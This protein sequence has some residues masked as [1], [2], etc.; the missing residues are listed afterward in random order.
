MKK[1]VT[2]IKNGLY[3]SSCKYTKCDSDINIEICLDK[4]VSNWL[5]MGGAITEATAYNYSK[6]N[7]SDKKNYIK[8]VF[9]DK[10]IDYN[11]VRLGIASNDFSLEPYQYTYKNDLS[12]FSLEKDKAY[13]VPLLD[14]VYKIKRPTLIASPWSPPSFM[15]SNKS[16]F[17][18][19]HLK[20]KYYDLYA[21]YLIKYIDEYKKM[22]Y[23]ID[24]LTIQNEPHAKQRWESCIFSLK[25]QKDFIY[26]YLLK[27]LSDTKVLIWDHN[28]EKL[29]KVMD[30]VYCE[31]KLVS[32]IGF[33]WYTGLYFN[34]IHDVRCKY[35]N[36]LVINT[37][38]CCGFSKYDEVSWVSDAELYLE[39]IIGCMNNGVNAYLEWNLLLDYNGGP[40]HK[41]NYVKSSIIL[42]ED[43]ST[44]IK[45]QFIIMFVI[46]LS[47]LKK[48]L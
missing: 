2:D 16:L 36:S 44:Y 10:G 32:G 20:H 34:N 22:G 26:N 7:K 9:S 19:G 15:K 46:F 39:D 30:K 42:N 41:E 38:M 31:N 33:H 45:T 5:G 48:I 24:Y 43:A 8:D 18:G 1:I 14:E 17:K 35:P 12:D 3:L 47:I 37:E 21:D 23:K 11:F 6:L 27:K 25:D 4:V 29:L 13:I 40:S 28:R